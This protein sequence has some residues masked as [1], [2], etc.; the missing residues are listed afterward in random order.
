MPYVMWMITVLLPVLAAAAIVAATYLYF[1][2]KPLCLRAL[3]AV[4]FLGMVASIFSMTSPRLP[5][6]LLVTGLGFG[7]AGLFEDLKRR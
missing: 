4:G 1:N 3:Y 6:L 2:E 7:V 5:F